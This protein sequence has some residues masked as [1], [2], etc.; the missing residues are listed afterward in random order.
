MFLQEEVSTWLQPTN[1]VNSSYSIVIAWRLF[2]QDVTGLR[3]RLATEHGE[4]PLKLQLS[5]EYF[6]LHACALGNSSFVLPAQSAAAC[7]ARSNPILQGI[8]QLHCYLGQF[9][10]EWTFGKVAAAIHPLIRSAV[11]GTST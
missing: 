6:P 10:S 2:M 8:K 11:S 1:P 5:I 9:L 4:P 3:A 7:L